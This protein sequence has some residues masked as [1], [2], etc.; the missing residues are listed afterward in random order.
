MLTEGQNA[1]RLLNLDANLLDAQQQEGDDDGGGD[2]AR[3][4]GMVQ[5]EGHEGEPNDE[6]AARVP[7]PRTARHSIRE[8]WTRTT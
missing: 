5:G 6:E 3:A 1:E 2:A 7:A 4:A 8:P